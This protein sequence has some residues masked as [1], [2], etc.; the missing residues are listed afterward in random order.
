MRRKNV[1][2]EKP[3]PVLPNGGAEF[4]FLELEA[5]AYI[6]KNFKIPI[7]QEDSVFKGSPILLCQSINPKML[8]TIF[9]IAM[10][11]QGLIPSEI[12][13]GLKKIYMP[14]YLKG[15]G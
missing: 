9:S 12:T 13:S 5:K 10:D 6:A 2:V 3:A 14:N 4:N 8:G 15:T 1:Q 7:K 11:Q